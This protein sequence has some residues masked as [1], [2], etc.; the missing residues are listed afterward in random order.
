M[1]LGK[2][3]FAQIIEFIPRREFNQFVKL[4]GGDLRIRNLVCR[5]QLLVL[6]FG[7]L[8]NLRSLRG[9]VLCLNAHSNLLYHLGF[10]T[11][12]FTLSTLSRANENRDF[13]IYQDLAQLLIKQARKLY[14][15]DNDFSIELDGAVYALDSTVIELCLATFKWAYFELGKSAVKIHTQLDLRG[16]IPAFFHI[17]NAKTHDINFLDVLESEAGAF[18][19][20][21]RGYFDFKRLFKINQAK[22]FFIIRAKKSISYERMYSREVDKSTGLRY[23]QTTKLK[24][25]YS[26]KHYPEK[27]RRI[28]YYDSEMNRYYIY[29]TNNFEIDAKKVADLYKHRRQ[30]ELFFRWIKQHLKIEVFRGYSTNAVKTQICIALCAFLLVAVMKKKLGIKQNLYEILQILSVSQ[31]EKT[32]INA[33]LSKMNLQNF[34]EQTEKQ[35]TLFDF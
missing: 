7:Q 10:K 20:M 32:P 28:K 30:I 8:A 23:D 15:N 25:F 29:L 16:N 19:I 1:H 33:M 21:D 13:R 14:L 12:N 34:N 18:Y 17:T 24:H 31:F 35:L 11:N 6:V 4:Y 27:L 2:Y 3:V 26:K 5:D 22:A 9:V